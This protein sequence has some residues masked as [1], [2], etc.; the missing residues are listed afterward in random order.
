[1]ERALTHV[2]PAPLDRSDALVD[3]AEILIHSQRNFPEAVEL[4]RT[5][6]NSGKKVE[7]APA[8]KV[9]YL[10]GTASEKL[11]DKEAAAAEYRSALAL[12]KEFQPAQQALQR[13]NR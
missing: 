9:H 2:R 1:M 13:M 10:L 7:Q 5:Y 8:F 3:A 12:A 11:G 4:L 6:L